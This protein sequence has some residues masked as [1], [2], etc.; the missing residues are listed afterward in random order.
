M[1]QQRTL[2]KPTVQGRWHPSELIAG[3]VE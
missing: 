2:W 1:T 3:P